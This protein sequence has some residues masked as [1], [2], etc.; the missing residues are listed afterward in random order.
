MC[1]CTYDSYNLPED[2]LGSH[3]ARLGTEF[4]LILA[5]FDR[6]DYFLYKTGA[7][8]SI[9]VYWLQLVVQVCG[10]VSTQILR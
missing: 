2:L 10:S 9:L 3:G 1:A 6:Y 7:L 8:S 4:K 5:W